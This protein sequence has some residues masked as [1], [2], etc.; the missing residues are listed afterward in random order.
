MK[1]INIS[2]HHSNHWRRHCDGF[3][4]FIYFNDEKFK[5]H[6]CIFSD[7]LILEE[8]KYTTNASLK[9]IKNVA[10]GRRQTQRRRIDDLNDSS[11]FQNRFCPSRISCPRF[12]NCY[13][14][15]MKHSVKKFSKNDN[16]DGLILFLKV[17]YLSCMT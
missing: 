1:W 9:S 17:L 12:S 13:M 3:T 7:I 8:M 11:I 10:D 15:F 6:F 2:L 4:W 16:L 5:I 14:K